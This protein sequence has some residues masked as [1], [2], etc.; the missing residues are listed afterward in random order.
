MFGC[1][2]QFKVALGGAAVNF[3]IVDLVNQYS[4]LGIPFLII[5]FGSMVSRAVN[6]K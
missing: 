5:V 3:S 4:L 1:P 2:F 6:L